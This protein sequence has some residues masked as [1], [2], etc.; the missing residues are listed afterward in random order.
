V[1]VTNVV[2][3]RIQGYYQ[4][5]HARDDEHLVRDLQKWELDNQ[6][7]SFHTPTVGAGS[8]MSYYE[9]EDA[10]KVIAWLEKNN[11]R[12]L[13]KKR[14]TV[15][16][17]ITVTFE[18]P[19]HETG[20]L[21]LRVTGQLFLDRKGNSHSCPQKACKS[22]NRTLPAITFLKKARLKLINGIQ[23]A[24]IEDSPNCEECEKKEPVSIHMQGRTL[25]MRVSLRDERDE[26]YRTWDE[27]ERYWAAISNRGIRRMVRTGNMIEF[28]P[29]NDRA[30]DKNGIPYKS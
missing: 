30:H 11:K 5:S 14:R 15:A 23:Y 13:E 2:A 6:I 12:K 10:E 4:D 17:G 28:Q 7:Y 20:K 25:R 22:C 9:P 18:C 21:H 1:T 29:Y 24:V 26:P 3:V 8:M 19:N 27:K 16:D